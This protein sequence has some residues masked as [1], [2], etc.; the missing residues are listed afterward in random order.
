[1]IHIWD[2]LK[3]LIN[4]DF[5]AV[6]DFWISPKCNSQFPKNNSVSFLGSVFGKRSRMFLIQEVD[7]MRK[8]N[9]KGRCEKRMIG[10]CT[11]VCKTYDAIQYAYAD[12]LQGSDEV[13][14]IRCNVLLDGLD[15]GE[16]TSDFVRKCG[17]CDFAGGRKKEKAKEYPYIAGGNRGVGSGNQTML[18]DV[19]LECEYIP[20]CR[21][22]PL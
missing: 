4:G 8:K 20:E 19:A 3:T 1:M 15:V 10:K 12:F 13:K 9:F 2:G 21:C 17:F 5:K 6:D 11:E 7:G 14:E 16:Y 22:C 18:F